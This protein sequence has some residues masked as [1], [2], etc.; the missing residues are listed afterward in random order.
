VAKAAG[1]PSVSVA[2]ELG[3][4]LGERV[5]DARACRRQVYHDHVVDSLTLCQQ[6]I[7]RKG[8][9]LGLTAHGRDECSFN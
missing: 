5:L 2:A 7:Q 9:Y 3:G 8:Y 6:P 1:T 4:K